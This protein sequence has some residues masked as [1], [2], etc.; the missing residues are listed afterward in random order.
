M[1]QSLEAELADLQAH[2]L[3]RQLR[4]IDSPQ[5]P[6]MEFAGQKL[7]NF[8]SN[9]YLGLAAEAALKTAAKEAIEQYGVGAGASRL[10]CGTLSPHLRLEE[11]L[12]EFK[13]TEAA[14]TFSSGYATAVGTLGALA[15]KD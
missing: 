6:S 10:V 4:E 14:L 13:R 12:A 8:S 3:L 5:Q 7:V 2:A 9:D 11:R 15:H 1:A